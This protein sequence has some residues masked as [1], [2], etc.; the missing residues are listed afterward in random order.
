MWETCNLQMRPSWDLFWNWRWWHRTQ[1]TAFSS[2]IQSEMQKCRRLVY[3]Y[4]I[5][6]HLKAVNIY[7]VRSSVRSRESSDYTNI[8]N[9]VFNTIKIPHFSLKHADNATTKEIKLSACSHSRLVGRCKK[10]AN[11]LAPCK[12]SV[13]NNHDDDNL[14]NIKRTDY[15]SS[16]IEERLSLVI[17]I[18]ATHTKYK[19]MR[20]YFR[21]NVRS[22]RVKLMTTKFDI[23]RS[24][25][26]CIFPFSTR[27]HSFGLGRLEWWKINSEKHWQRICVVRNRHS[28]SSAMMMSHPKFVA[29]VTS[30]HFPF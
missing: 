20:W 7:S 23:V 13:N 4:E 10:V 6:I 15:P 9:S 11:S 29:V 21:M 27:S 17:W 3:L 30:S 16:I 19:Y 2:N 1:L 14:C 26:K 22:T 24:I 5:R 28:M 25:F 8:T 18:E 12:Q